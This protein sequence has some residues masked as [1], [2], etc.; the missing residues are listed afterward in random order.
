MVG[1]I[2]EYAARFAKAH[3]WIKL[4]EILKVRRPGAVY[5]YYVCIE[6]QFKLGIEW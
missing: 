2:W 3:S 6:C 4:V 1:V 5:Y